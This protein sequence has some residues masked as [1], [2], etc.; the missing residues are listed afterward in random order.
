[1][2]SGSGRFR[3]NSDETT[4]NYTVALSPN[5]VNAIY[6]E[7]P[8]ATVDFGSNAYVITY[9][10]A[11]PAFAYSQ[12]SAQNGDAALTGYSTV[13][14]TATY[15]TSLNI[16]ASATP[17]A[18]SSSLRDLGYAIA[19]TGEAS[20]V[21]NKKSISISNV[22][23]TT[24]VY[25]GN[26]TATVDTAATTIVGKVMNDVLT[27]ASGAG[28]FDDRNVGTGKNVTISSVTYGGADK[29]NYSYSASPAGV[30]AITQ[31]S[32]ATWVGGTGDWM[33]R[34]VA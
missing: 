20:L 29:D 24:K 17:Y 27:I 14:P 12:T 26:T 5:V 16:K 4:T 2:G 19:T 6:R 1:V 8:T 30:G 3:Y 32:S 7:Q 18:L 28:V 23:A 15:S 21:V 33:N 11:L 22:T 10:D 25:D 9:G 13:I 34:C 31:L